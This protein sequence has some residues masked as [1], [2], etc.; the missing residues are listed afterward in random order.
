MSSA[1]WS[2][3]I[4]IVEPATNTGSSTAYGVFAPVRPTF[5][6]IRRSRVCACCAGNLNA[7]AHRG[8]LAVA[9]RRA[10]SARSSTLITTPSVSKSSAS[11]FSAH[12]SQNSA[13]CAMPSQRF[14]CGSTG[15]PHEAKARKV[16][17]CVGANGSSAGPTLRSAAGPE[18]GRATSWYT[19][20]PSPRFDTKA[21]SRLRI[22]P[23][24]ALRGFW[25]NVSPAVSRS[26][27]IRANDAR[28]RYTSP[29]TSI[30]PGGPRRSA[31][32][33]ARIVRT[34]A[35]TSSP[36][37]PSPRVAPRTRRLSS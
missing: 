21:G 36:R 1:L 20:E 24:A 27:F 22:V 30:R 29:R 17:E 37:T 18:R 11:R 25:N 16:S 32:G 9:P 3:A 4:E 28:G 2:V 19:Y 13:T 8:N 23:A 15:R 12:S 6:S 26:R 34:F 35:V 14:Q 31:R 5:T 7:V 10:R 33:M